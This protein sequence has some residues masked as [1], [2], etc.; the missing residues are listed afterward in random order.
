MQQPFAET[1]FCVVNLSSREEEDK[2]M[3]D[4]VML[5]ALIAVNKVGYDCFFFFFTRR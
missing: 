5:H 2:D 3:E 4:E 1:E